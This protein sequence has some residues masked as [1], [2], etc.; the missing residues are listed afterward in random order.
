MED[1]MN[2]E[3]LCRASWLASQ[4]EAAVT[5]RLVLTAASFVGYAM[6]VAYGDLTRARMLVPLAA[7]DSVMWARV[8]DAFDQIEQDRRHGIVRPKL[9]SSGGGQQ[10]I[11]GRQ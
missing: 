6:E 5:G 1:P 3:A 4:R 10:A 7:I 9:L 2:T 8:C 11:G